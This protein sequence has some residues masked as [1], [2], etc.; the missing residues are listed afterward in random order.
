MASPESGAHCSMFGLA[1]DASCDRFRLNKYQVMAN[2]ILF[3][4]PYR[5][6]SQ[7]SDDDGR[8]TLAGYLN[9]PGYKPAGRL[10]YDSE[11]LLVLTDDGKLQHQIANPS[12]KLWKRYLV[13]VEGIATDA[14][15]QSL[16]AG[17]VLK[18][19]ATRPAKAV[20]AGAP[21]V[22]PRNPPIRQRKNIPTSWLSIA[23]REGR[24]RQVRRMTAAVGLPTLRLIRVAVGDWSVAGLAPGEHRRL[25]VN[26]VSQGVTSRARRHRPGKGKRT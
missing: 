10:D 16:R 18:D 8:D 9:A 25:Q 22:W 21:D 11:G 20:A 2:I 1:R 5:V 19:G 17:V 6:L 23:I 7:F 12:Q 4:K 13:Q 14:A 3:N 24:N 26:T 15:L